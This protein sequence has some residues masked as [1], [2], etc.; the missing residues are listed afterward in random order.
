[1]H[2]IEKMLFLMI[3]VCLTSCGDG[4]ESKAPITEE[5]PS[6][7]TVEKE[8][9]ADQQL[10]EEE[11]EAFVNGVIDY[12]VIAR[13]F[14]ECS[15]KAIQVQKDTEVVIKNGIDQEKYQ[16]VSNLRTS[17]SEEAITCCIAVKAQRTK[18]KLDKVKLSESFKTECK[19]LPPQLMIQIL[20][21]AIY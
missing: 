16:E 20:L 19:D 5:N 15:Q 3:L 8:D 1:M 11:K 7:K 21:K 17:S 14:C 2:R 13:D 4:T 6:T 12:N 18:S 9:I 10:S